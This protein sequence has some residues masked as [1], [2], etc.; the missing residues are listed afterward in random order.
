LRFIRGIGSFV[1]WRYERGTWQFDLMCA[2]ILGFIFLTPRSLFT[3][4]PQ[5][6]PGQVVAIAGA[7]GPGYRIEASVLAGSARSLQLSARQVLEEV[8]GHRIKIRQMQPVLDSQ[9]RVESYT[10]LVQE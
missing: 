5:P 10:V 6:A 9:G 4:R 3:D 1:F 2:I 7:N 8:T